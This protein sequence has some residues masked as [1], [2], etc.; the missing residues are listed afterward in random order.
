MAIDGGMRKQLAAGMRLV[1]KYASRSTRRRWSRARTGSSAS[2]SRTARLQQ[3]VGGGLG[4]DE[5]HRVQ[6]LA[7]LVARDRRR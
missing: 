2:G 3:P 6:R 5:R 4:G 7:L 1:A